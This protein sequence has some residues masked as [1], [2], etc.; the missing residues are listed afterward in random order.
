[1]GLKFEII[2]G[3][4]NIGGFSDS[5]FSGVFSFFLLFFSIFRPENTSEEVKLFILMAQIDREMIPA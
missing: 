3:V 2:L 1:M 4:M 5:L